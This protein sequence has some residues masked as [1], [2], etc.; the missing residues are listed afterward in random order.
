[1]PIEILHIDD[2]R[3][4]LEL[5]KSFL[6]KE[7]DEPSITT[8]TDA[9]AVLSRLQDGTV[10]CIISDY[11]MP[12]RDGLELLQEV[13]EQYPELPFILYTGKGSEEIAADAINAGVTGYLQKGG[14]DQLQRLANRTRHAA[15]EYRSRI[16]SE[17]YSTVLRALGYPVY[18]VNEE[19]EF[20]Y[21]NQEFV[22]L[23]GY[24]R[25]KILGSGPELIKTDEGVEKADDMLAEIVSSSGP[26]K[27]KFE[28]DIHSADG[29]II[30]CYDHMAALPFDD[31]FRGSVGIL[32]DATTE[33]RRR[34][35]LIQ[36]NERLDEFTS[37][38]SHDLR[39]PLSNAKTAAQ[40][41]RTT[42][43]ADAFDQLEAQ[44]E[45]MG[46]MI[47]DLLTLA[48]EGETIS[49]TERVDVA[50]IAAEA[51]DSFSCPANTL[52]L[53]D[54]EL[55]INSDTSRLRRLL[56]NV[57]R[58][59]VEHSSSPVTVTVGQLDNGF[60]L[61]DNGPGIDEYERDQVF[62]PGYT[63]T[64]SGTGFG[65]SIV[66]R[67]ADTHGWNISLTDSETGGTQFEF[68]TDPPTQSTSTAV[69]IS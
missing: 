43:D 63:T 34:E 17:R 23:T 51:W 32:R 60:Y 30:P 69:P 42:D 67:I 2:D 59:A 50:T 25:D 10:H 62:E 56:E 3:S 46:E 26:N 35:E 48:R 41:A 54:D 7:L 68:I 1:M 61:A 66:K 5:T 64:E 12:H 20:E 49:E 31:T 11:D 52:N 55:M 13:R 24:D 36:Q 57:L 33:Q 15:V 9:E 37:I 27:Q 40:L 14:P 65:L 47:D 58:N 6:T 53:P 21:V 22:E 44:H 45:R 8:V 19:G 18:V 38:V 29:D 28:V 16:E 39:T 4:I